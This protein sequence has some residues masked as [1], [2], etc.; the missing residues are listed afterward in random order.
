[1]ETATANQQHCITTMS[2][3]RPRYYA[4]KI[5]FFSAENCDDFGCDPAELWQ[6]M[7]TEIECWTISGTHVGIVTNNASLTDLAA[8]LDSKLEDP[9]TIVA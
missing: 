5:T 3:Y 2:N 9:N 4:G 8:A 7:A 6:G 1:M